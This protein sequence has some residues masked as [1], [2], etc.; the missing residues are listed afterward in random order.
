MSNDMENKNNSRAGSEWA[1]AKHIRETRGITAPSLRR[2]SDFG[3]IRTSNIIRPGQTR[4]IRLYSVEDVDR[5][6]VRSIQLPP[7]Q[8][9]DFIPLGE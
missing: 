7:V 3:L 5:L 1:P 9:E 4:G 2:L 8:D 6:I